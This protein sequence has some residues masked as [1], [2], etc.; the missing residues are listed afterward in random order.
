VNIRRQTDNRT[1]I[2]CVCIR[3][4]HF[5]TGD[6]AHIQACIHLHR[7][8]HAHLH[9]RTHTGV[10]LYLAPEIEKALDALPPGGGSLPLA[11]RFIRRA[12]SAG[13]AGKEGGGDKARESIVPR[14][15]ETFVTVDTCSVLKA[16]VED[17]YPV[18]PNHKIVEMVDRPTQLHEI[19]LM[20]QRKPAGRE[21]AAEAYRWLQDEWGKFLKRSGRARED[22]GTAGAAP[23]G[24]GGENRV[25]DT[26]GKEQPHKEKVH[27]FDDF[28]FVCKGNELLSLGFQELLRQVYM[29]CSE[30][31]RALEYV[32]RLH[33]GLTDMAFEYAKQKGEDM[34]LLQS[35]SLFY[36]S[37]EDRERDVAQRVETLLAS[38]RA[39]Y[40]AHMARA[41]AHEEELVYRFVGMEQ[42][43]ERL[44]IKYEKSKKLC[45]NMAARA[46]VMRDMLNDAHEACACFLMDSQGRERDEREAL[47]F[48]SSWGHRPAKELKRQ[49]AYLQGI[50]EQPQE[51]LESVSIEKMSVWETMHDKI[52]DL[53][54]ESEQK[55]LGHEAEIDMY[56]RSLTK[57]IDEKEVLREELA[58]TKTLTVLAYGGATMATTGVQCSLVHGTDPDSKHFDDDVPEVEEPP[59]PVAATDDDDLRRLFHKMDVDNSG[60]LSIEEFV[61]AMTRMRMGILVPPEQDAINTPRSAISRASSGDDHAHRQEK[62]QGRKPGERQA[63][64]VKTAKVEE[65]VGIMRL[66]KEKYKGP[67]MSLGKLL[68]VI[69]EAYV[70]KMKADE[71]DD[72]EQNVRAAPHDFFYDFLLTRFGLKSM[73][74]KKMVE[75]VASVAQ[76]S[77][78][79]LVVKHFGQFLGI[80]NGKDYLGPAEGNSYGDPCG[81]LNVYLDVL[82]QLKSSK[83]GKK[84]SDRDS[85]TGLQLISRFRLQKEI[86]GIIAWYG[87][88]DV[89]HTFLHPSTIDE[90]DEGF[91]THQEH[92]IPNVPPEQQRKP[93]FSHGPDN[94]PDVDLDLV[95]QKAI[96]VG[97][98]HEVH[99]FK[100]MLARFKDADTDGDGVMTF[101]EFQAFAASLD[102]MQ[103]KPKKLKSLFREMLE[104]S[105]GAGGLEDSIS[106]L[107]FVRHAITNNLVDPALRVRSSK[108]DD[109]SPLKSKAS[110]AS[111]FKAAA[112][113]AK[114]SREKECAHDREG[115]SPSEAVGVCVRAPTYTI[116]RIYV[117]STCMHYYIVYMVSTRNVLN[118]VCVCVCVCE[119]VFACVRAPR[120][121]VRSKKS[122]NPNN[123]H[124]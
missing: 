56:K 108:N 78:S 103:V 53:V 121:T 14:A 28:T 49:Q 74:D 67:T 93:H 31:G 18:P 48:N 72:R 82:K 81:V 111:K 95:L 119:C 52:F 105:A 104:E 99:L 85:T 110:S 114:V 50:K 91:K 6:H 79:C 70:D 84:V 2:A 40:E 60:S 54:V 90:D 65:K 30:R 15:R 36:K 73:A 117:Y 37:E 55:R 112:K 98:S 13:H 47:S 124:L 25:D 3:G 122:E 45:R 75:I 61:S 38:E 83:H 26:R 11:S 94:S 32:W 100:G 64:K 109:N 101:E 115:D 46:A 88:S 116:Y 68:G 41:Q 62:D 63:V 42:M 39:Q 106:P 20:P 66:V 97:K 123:T 17:G 86:P 4:C 10:P 8:T 24:R 102:N 87:N 69:D 9:V 43:I 1:D 51:I 44:T 22:K 58:R 5:H 96:E 76:W 27:A 92:C 89:A 16:A 19:Y 107:V 118:C 12:S 7:Y 113:L 59:P 77:K 35:Q 23:K 34:A 57:A 71:T 21:D 29:Y 33:L 120:S 80:C